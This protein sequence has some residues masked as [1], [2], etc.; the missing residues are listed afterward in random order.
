MT[1]DDYKVTLDR[2]IIEILYTEEP[3]DIVHLKEE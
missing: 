3:L 1:T 2:L